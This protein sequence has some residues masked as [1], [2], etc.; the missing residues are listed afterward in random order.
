MGGIGW[1]EILMIL[2]VALIIFGPRK[3]PEL[4]KSL[5]QGLAHFRRASEDFK[6]TWEEEVESEKRRIQSYL[7]DLN[8]PLEPNPALDS[9]PYASIYDPVPQNGEANE[10][11][12][13]DAAT[14]DE[15]APSEGAMETAAADSS[16]TTTTEVVATDTS[17]PADAGSLP[18]IDDN[19]EAGEERVQG[20]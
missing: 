5:A 17:I 14:G 1:A 9:N 19:A 6:R 4:G 2:V 16:D 10:S 13:P 15:S 11:S 3:L 20:H 7:P 12:A 18:A 8:S